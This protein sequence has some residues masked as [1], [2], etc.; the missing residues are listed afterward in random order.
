MGADRGL[1][2]TPSAGAAPAT[3]PAPAAED[4]SHL[5]TPVPRCAG[6]EV[7]VAPGIGVLVPANG[8]RGLGGLV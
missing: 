4:I 7:E 2:T 6:S 5:Q 8:L 3:V 1:D